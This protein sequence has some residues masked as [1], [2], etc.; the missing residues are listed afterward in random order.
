MG[1]DNDSV[2]SITKRLDAIIRLFMEQQNKNGQ[3][4]RSEQ[5]LILDSVGLNS[6]DIGS[7]V[8]QSPSNVSSFLRK[9]KKNQ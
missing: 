1:N 3:L 6:G 5:M 7:I 8:N 9:L 4:N 2:E